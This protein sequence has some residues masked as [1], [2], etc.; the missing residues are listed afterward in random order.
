R[1]EAALIDVRH[2]FAAG[3]QFIAP[4][5]KLSVQPSARGELKFGFGRQLLAR[6]LRISGGVLPRDVADGMIFAA[7][8]RTVSAFGTF[9]VRARRVSPPRVW[10]VERYVM[11]RRRKHCAARNQF[12]GGRAGKIFGIGCAFGDGLVA[13]GLHKLIELSVSD[14]SL[15]HPEAVDG[16]K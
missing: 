12:F 9:A 3:L 6:P 1:R 11:R 16:D 5:I 15:V 14:R 4:G 13:G 2:P 7:L 10:I 8:N